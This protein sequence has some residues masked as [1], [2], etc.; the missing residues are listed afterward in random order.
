MVFQKPME[1][2]EIKRGNIIEVK[3]T[4]VAFGGKGIAKIA[5]EQ[6]DFVVFVPNTFT[7]QQ[8]SARVVKKRK[9]MQNVS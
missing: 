3:I 7:G 6:G 8:V 1:L 2:A 9:N 4:D 5:T